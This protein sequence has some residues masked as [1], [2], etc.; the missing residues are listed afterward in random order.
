VLTDIENLKQWQKAIP[1]KGNTGQFETL[2][3][4]ELR[5]LLGLRRVKMAQINYLV[6]KNKRSTVCRYP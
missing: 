4:V 2:K 5:S 1:V 6:A 3:K